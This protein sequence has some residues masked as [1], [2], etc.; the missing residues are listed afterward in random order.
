M[1]PPTQHAELSDTLRDDVAAYAFG[2]LQ[3][4]QAY[5]MARHLE[6]GCPVCNKELRD[7]AGVMTALA[8]T[9]EEKAPKPSIKDRLLARARGEKQVDHPGL[10]V[11]RPGEGKWRKTRWE[12][13]QF[14]L[15]H[16]DKQTGASTSLVRVDPGGRYPAH[17][18]RGT[19]QTWVLQGSCR[20]GAI[21]IQAGDYAC[22]AAGSEHGE[23]VS[24]RGCLLLI[25]SAARDEVLA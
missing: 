4:E 23:L 10:Y 11:V 19:E 5:N 8:C 17:R 6:T 14:L 1:I 12:G 22:A 24:D 9:V 3:G 21:T 7:V 2:I 15:L 18:H 16:S 13:V 25:I 20:I